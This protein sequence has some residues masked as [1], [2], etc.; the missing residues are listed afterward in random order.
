MKLAIFGGTGR[1]GKH[2]VEQALDAGH[3][4]KA[5]VRTPSKLTIEHP[6]LHVIQGDILN[7]EQVE[8]TIEG[9]DAVI[10]TLGPTSN[11]PEF[12]ISQGMDNILEAMK[13]HNV[14][15]IVVSTGAGVR[16]PEDNPKLID[17]FFGFLLNVISKNV[18]A[19]ME[20][21]IRK[22]QASDRD[23][24]I[25]RVPMLTDQAAQGN[26]IVGYVGDIKPRITRADMA[27]FMLE[28]VDKNDFLKKAPAI[29]NS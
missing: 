9:T 17:R 11:K 2:T 14:Q 6:N 27:S 18:V 7:A 26:L 1:T 15:R 3:T 29:S 22:L 4:V 19:D 16:Q 23:W 5:L 21:A 10:S 28:Q 25:V 24:V 13:K 12:V 8:A 20:Q